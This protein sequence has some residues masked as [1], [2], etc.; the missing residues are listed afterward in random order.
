LHEQ[1]RP[2]RRVPLVFRENE[3]LAFPVREHAK[4]IERLLDSLGS[5][6]AQKAEA[7]WPTTFA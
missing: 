5:L 7:L 6:P 3:A 4:L 2:R 1:C